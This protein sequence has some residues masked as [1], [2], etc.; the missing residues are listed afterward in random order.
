MAGGVSLRCATQLRELPVEVI[1]VAPTQPIETAATPTGTPSHVGTTMQ[2]CII[3]DINNHKHNL[4][5]TVNGDAAALGR[6]L[7]RVKG[8]ATKHR[9]HGGFGAALRLF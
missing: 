8:C 6:A 5:N 9:V 1:A 3:I 4:I 2:I 7:Q